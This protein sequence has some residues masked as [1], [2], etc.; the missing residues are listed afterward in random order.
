MK[1]GSSWQRRR[2]SPLPNKLSS[3][4]ER[5]STTRLKA[6]EKN[7]DL[8]RESSK[9]SCRTRDCQCTALPPKADIAERNHH[10]RFVPKGDI[11]SAAKSRLFNHLV[12]AREQRRRHVDAKHLR[13]LEIDHQLELGRPL[14]R[15]V[16][17]LSAL[18]N[19]PGIKA[20]QPVGVG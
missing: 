19:L 13:S 3:K 12:G 8:F 17:R 16:R 10:V 18:E 7:R 9:S 2:R 14:D 11:R 4:R 1:T 5:S 15:Q 20:D 6:Q